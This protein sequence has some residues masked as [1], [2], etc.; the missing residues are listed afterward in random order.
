[1]IRQVILLLLLL[2][3]LCLEDQASSYVVRNVPLKA[4]RL[5]RW[6]Q[7][8]SLWKRKE[9]SRLLPVE[10]EVRLPVSPIKS[11]AD[12]LYWPKE[13]IATGWKIKELSSPACFSVLRWAAC[14]AAE[15]PDEARGWM[16]IWG[17]IPCQVSSMRP[18]DEHR[19][20][21]PFASVLNRPGGFLGL[22]TPAFTRARHMMSLMAKL[23]CDRT[24]LSAYRSMLTFRAT[25][26]S[27]WQTWG[28]YR[29]SP[30]LRPTATLTTSLSRARPH[31]A[32]GIAISQ[33]A[34]WRL[35]AASNLALLTRSFPQR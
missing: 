18:W 15:P 34:E 5:K 8:E 30:N 27:Q 21:G 13:S 33:S 24:C 3:G 23:R 4:T 12:R 31:D 7:M 26:A 1:M 19:S 22:G 25:S 20:I 14:S 11:S 10:R 28:P 16:Y 2:L 32:I 29:S 17:S 6:M 9:A 35:T